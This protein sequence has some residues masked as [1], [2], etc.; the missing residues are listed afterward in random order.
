MSYAS[1]ERKTNMA[2]SSR[3]AHAQSPRLPSFSFS[4]HPVSEAGSPT[5]DDSMCPYSPLPSGEGPHRFSPS[6]VKDWQSRRKSVSNACERCRRRKIRCDGDTPCATCKRFS[7]QC[8]RTQKPREAIATEHQAALESRIHQL[9]SQLAAHVNAPM[10]GMESIEQSLASAGPSSFGWQSPPPP[11]SVDTSFS[12]PFSPSSDMLGSFSAGSMP[13]I[14]ISECEPAPISPPSTSPVPSQWSGTT[15]ASS[16]ELPPPTSAPHFPPSAFPQSKAPHAAP[17]WEFMAQGTAGRLDPQGSLG[18]DFSRKTSISSGSVDEDD[19]AI[20]SFEERESSADIMPLAPAPRLPRHGIFGAHTESP[21]P[22]S[23]RP[24]FSDRS[25]AITAIPFPSRF[26]A[27]TLTS[28][29]VEH[30]QAFEGPKPYSIGPA[31][32]SRICESVYPDPTGR[33]TSADTSISVPMARFHVFLAM[34]IGM[35]VRIKDS[36]EPTNSLLDRCYELAMQQATSAIFWQ[37]P[38]G[39]EAAQLL[40]VFAAI[41]KEQRFEPKPLQSSFSW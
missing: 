33:A 2:L 27:E 29:F 7:L 22:G 23:A 24:T 3:S 10:H 36:S 26:E 8:V 5:V 9:E 11:L 20:S 25:R 19:A 6:S 41:R 34:A 4:D 18:G 40:S 15:R 37:E 39:V 31:H 12:Q 14:A 21:P 16:P 32:F 13:S 1:A 38:G 35:K 28:E 17:S 30:I